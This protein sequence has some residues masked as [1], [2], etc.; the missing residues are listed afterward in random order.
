MN[1]QR[2][3]NEPSRWYER[4]ETYR[5]LG[6]TRSIEHAFRICTNSRRRPGAAWYK[7]ANDWNWT[8]RAEAWD[9]AEREQLRAAE[10]TRRFDARQRRLKRIEELQTQAYEAL[11]AANL[12]ELTEELARTLIGSLRAIFEAMMRAERLEYGD[13]VDPQRNETEF[14]ADDFAL[15]QHQLQLWTRKSNG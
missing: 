5:L 8:A 13:L 4:F 14:T 10:A 15:A 2:Q 9:E 7:T 6:S 11:Q 3:P 1:W 12:P